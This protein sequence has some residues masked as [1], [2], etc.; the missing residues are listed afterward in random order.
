MKPQLEGLLPI[1]KPSGIT[2]HDVVDVVRK[3]MRVR[4][5]GH[6]GTLDPQ[7]TGL[8]LI[9]LGRATRMTEYL[10]DLDKEYIAQMVLGATTDT[11]D[12]DGQITD[13]QPTDHLTEAAIRDQFGNFVGV[14][15]QKPPMLSATHHEGKRLYELARQGI[16]VERKSRPVTV[17]RLEML[18]CCVQ[19]NRKIVKYRTVCSR[20]TYIRTL[21]ADIGKALGCGAY[22]NSLIRTEVGPF[23]LSQAYSLPDLSMLARTKELHSKIWTMNE[24]LSFFPPV[25][26]TRIQAQ[27]L[28]N[29]LDATV[30]SIEQANELGNDRRVRVLAPGDTFIAVGKL[31]RRGQQWLCKPEKVFAPPE[32]T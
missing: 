7:A 10:F 23:Q 24:G 28:L 17:Y 5:V 4:R 9:C 27:R 25:R 22:L 21:C 19:G 2:S 15:Q 14:I 26:L 12:S 13:E 20:G 11:E 29:G 6:A 1:A 30:T 32:N 16:E 18:E 3:V 31:A 8:M